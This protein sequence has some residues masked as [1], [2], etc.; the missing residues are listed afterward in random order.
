MLPS[1]LDHQ[2]FSS[3]EGLIE[4]LPYLGPV[5]FLHVL[6]FDHSEQPKSMPRS[7]LLPIDSRRSRR[8]L[9][10]VVIAVIRLK[11]RVNHHVLRHF[12]NQVGVDHLPEVHSALSGSGTSARSSTMV[13]VAPSCI[14]CSD[15]SVR[16]RRCRMHLDLNP[17]HFSNLRFFYSFT[18]YV[19][20]IRNARRGE[21]RRG[22]SGGEAASLRE[23]PLPNP[24]SR[25]VAGNK[26]VCSFGG[27]R[28]CCV[29]AVSCCLCVVTAADR[30]AATCLRWGRN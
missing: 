29:G 9:H 23:A 16:A 17:I 19:I 7:M 12:L 30:A 3:A 18:L 20:P 5:L 28:P 15:T 21:R 27:S 8:A 26:L 1:W 22:D 13:P 14:S 6:R 24:L 25:R 10:A 2:R 11:P 4:P